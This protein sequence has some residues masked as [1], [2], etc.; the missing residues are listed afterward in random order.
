MR[1][2]PCF[3]LLLALGCDPSIVDAV[4]EPMPV[5]GSGGGGSGASEAGSGETG[6]TAGEAGSGEATGSPLATSLLHRYSFDGD[7]DVALDS[8]AAA[9]GQVVGTKLGGDGTLPLDGERSGQYLNLPNGLIS[10]LT[11]AT[12][13]MWLTWKGGEEWQ[14]IFD[15]GSNSSGE[16]VQGAAGKSYLFLATSS[17]PVGT[18]PAVMR[19]AY[20][21]DGPT[22]EEICNSPASLPTDVLT[23]VAVV[24]DSGADTMALFQDGA[25]IAE[26]PLK[27]RLSAINDVNNWLGHS[28]F[29]RDVDLAGTYLE[30]RVYDAALTPAQVAESFAAGPDAQP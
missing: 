25:P 3:P 17:T 10:P 2:R 29:Q 11:D 18:R 19:V 14:R 8:R 16:D 6:A 26:C 15:F 21:L 20:A 7:G 27:R 5:G 4:R 12:F 28:N 23:H 9:H 30:F 13:E 1:V 22:D 24:I